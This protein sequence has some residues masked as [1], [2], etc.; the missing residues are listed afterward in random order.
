VDTGRGANR[1][2]AIP[3]GDADP[4]GIA[5]GAAEQAGAPDD[6]CTTGGVW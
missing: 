4:A 5:A 2:G 1:F 3:G 6:I